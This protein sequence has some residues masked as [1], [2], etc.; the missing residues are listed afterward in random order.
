[1][2]VK[3]R[4]ERVCLRQLSLVRYASGQTLIMLT[5]LLRMPGSEVMKGRDS[6]RAHADKLHTALHSYYFV[7]VTVVMSPSFQGSSDEGR[8]VRSFVRD[9]GMLAEA[10]GRRRSLVRTVERRRAARQ[11]RY[12]RPSSGTA[13]TV[14]VRTGRPSSARSRSRIATSLHHT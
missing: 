7:T 1:M 8:L 10:W 6:W 9:G 2:G 3:Q 5:I 14:V 12:D 13:R 11:R 4:V